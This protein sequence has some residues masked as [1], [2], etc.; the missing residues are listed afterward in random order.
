MGN[1]RGAIWILAS[2]ITFSCSVSLVKFLGSDFPASVQGFYRQLV[3]LILVLPLIA[4]APRAALR[5]SRPWY[6][7]SRS[8]AMSMSIILFYTAYHQLPLA[9][10]NSLSFTRQLYMVP[11]AML[12]LREVVGW[13]RIIATFV[14]FGGVLVIL[15]PGARSSV[16]LINLPSFYCLLAALL[17]AWSVI[18]VK[19]MSKNHSQL[20]LLAWSAILGVLFTL[21]PA[22]LDWRI[23][24][25]W[26]L[27]LLILM[28][29]LSTTTQACYIRGM[30]LGDATVLAPLDYT[31]LIFTSLFGYLFFGEIP[32]A[33]M[34]AGS[35]I[36]IGA[37]IYITLDARRSY[38]AP[39]EKGETVITA[40]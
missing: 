11:L 9:Q 14:G 36:I 2:T 33:A 27:W 38:A 16:S 37:A 25:G 21:P 29:I 34:L 18:G 10:A 13:R 7:L 26:D 20:A 22:L 1:G 39:A 24:H 40:S 17:A 6:M 15:L 12:I 19:S 28:G 3:A 30:S 31:R 32:G 4:R 8:A 35:A 5:T 23:P